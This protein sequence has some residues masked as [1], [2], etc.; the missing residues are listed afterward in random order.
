MIYH[1]FRFQYDPGESWHVWPTATSLME[2]L[3]PDGGLGID[4]IDD[5]IQDWFNGIN[6]KLNNMELGLQQVIT[7]VKT[8]MARASEMLEKFKNDHKLDENFIRYCTVS[9]FLV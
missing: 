2:F 7:D 4:I 9:V 3:N 6:V 1:N 5:V 8:S